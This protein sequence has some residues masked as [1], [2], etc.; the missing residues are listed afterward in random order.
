MCGIVFVKGPS[1]GIVD[2][3]LKHY[4]AQKSRGVEGFGFVAMNGDKLS[5]NR[6]QH[7]FEIKKK[8]K[9]VSAHS[10]I[11][12]HHRYPTSTENIEE[13]AHPIKVSNKELEYDY[14]VVHNGVISN[15]D[16]LKEKHEKLGY[17]YTTE[18]EKYIQVKNKK[19]KQYITGS[20]YND[21][22][23]LAIELARFHEGLSTDIGTIGSVAFIMLQVDKKG[24]IIAIHYGR[25]SGNPLGWTIDGEYHVL[26][27]EGEEKI[28]VNTWYTYTYKTS[29]TTKFYVEIGQVYAYTG[30]NSAYG[31]NNTSNYSM[32][33][34]GG[35]NGDYDEYEGWDY[36]IGADG[37]RYKLQETASHARVNVCDVQLE[38]ENEGEYHVLAKEAIGLARAY[39]T[40]DEIEAFEDL[41]SGDELPKHW[42]ESIAYL[43]AE[44][45]KANKNEYFAEEAEYRDYINTLKSKV[46]NYYVDKYKKKEHLQDD[47]I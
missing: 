19:G 7:E 35:K 2:V 15:D 43:E 42:G 34:T 17:R 36:Y 1:K 47:I 40:I 12:F 14:Y 3:L 28:D 24:N 26:A 41:Y 4:K 20:E 32:G 27:S 46:S 33:F 23:A 38:D 39:D 31:S 11:L 45:V 9:K 21:S 13:A 44:A 25:N 37:K 29:M 16:K 8:L 22:E 5:W 10:E 18:I 30:A 6:T